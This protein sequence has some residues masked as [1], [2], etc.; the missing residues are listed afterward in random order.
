MVSAA[1]EWFSKNLERYPKR[2]S[3]V[4]ACSKAT[5][6]SAS[7]CRRVLLQIER[8]GGNKISATKP[9]KTALKIRTLAD[10]RSNHDVEKKIK[11]A[12]ES[13]PEDGYV[14]EQEIKDSIQ[15]DN[16]KFA[17]FRDHFQNNYLVVR[18]HGRHT[19]YWAKSGMIK[20]MKEIV[21]L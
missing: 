13:L 12:I 18:D 3:A 1:G 7:Q 15:I 11:T 10:F 16:N 9:L 6:I 14:T 21:D 20:K 19:T 4:K 5:G 2:S 17:R 8:S